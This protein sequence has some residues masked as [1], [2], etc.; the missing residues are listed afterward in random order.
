MELKGCPKCGGDMFPEEDLD[1]IDYVCLQCSYRKPF[2]SWTLADY[3]ELQ[4]A[5]ALRQR[6]PGKKAAA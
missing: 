6:R 3:A 4:L 5:K 1:G 2:R